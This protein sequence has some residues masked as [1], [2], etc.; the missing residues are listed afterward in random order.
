M[1][2]RLN[3]KF[4]AVKLALAAFALGGFA[5]DAGQGAAD[6]LLH[7]WS[8][9]GDLTDGLGGSA[10]QAFGCD[11]VASR[12][13]GALEL[14]GGRRNTSYADLGAAVPVDGS[15]FTVE[16]WA[17]TDGPREWSRVFEVGDGVRDFLVMTWSHG[18]NVTSE[19]CGVMADGKA[20]WQEGRFAPFVPRLSYHIALAVFRGERG[21]WKMRGWKQRIGGTEAPK[22][23]S[24]D[25]PEGWSPA[26]L[27]SGNLTLGHSL[28]RA[29]QDANAIYDEVRVWR[30]ALAETELAAHAEAGPDALLG[31]CAARRTPTRQKVTCGV[32]PLAPADGARECFVSPNGDDAADGSRA[33]P[34]R[35]IQRAASVASA[36]D[37]VTIRGGVYREWV[38]PA[39]AGAPGR[40]I[41][42][43]AAKGEH[44][45]VT[46]A[47]PVTDWT[48]LA[49]GR[50]MAQVEYTAF[51]GMNPF[52][53]FI[54]GNW[55]PRREDQFFRA[56]LLQGGKPL[57]LFTA[58]RAFAEIRKVAEVETG[59]RM[60]GASFAFAGTPETRIP[61]S[62]I[63]V[64]GMVCGTIVAAFE[65]DPNEM[66]PELTVRPACFYPVREGRD[67]LTLRGIEFRHAAPNWAPPTSEQVA[68]V[69]TNW[70]RGW[71]IEDCE[72]HGVV[73]AGLTL[74]KYGDEFDNVAETAK[75]YNSTVARACAHGLEKVGHHAVRRCRIHHC[76]QFGI[77]G[78]LG[79]M[80]STIEDC[81]ISHC[82]WKQP[83]GGVNM[84]GIDMHGT[85]DTTI[86][87]CRIHHCR[88]PYG[89]IWL[90][91]MSQ[92][93]RVTGN[94]LWGNECQDIYLEVNHGPI[95]VDGNDCLSTRSMR[96][97]SKNVALVDN[98]FRGEFQWAKQWRR[99]PLFEPH[100]VKVRSLDT[101]RC[102][103]GNFIFINN[104]FVKLPRFKGVEHPCR[105][106]DNWIVPATRWQ[107]DEMT[108]DC[109]IEPDP[110]NPR[111]AVR[112]VTSARLGRTVV[113]SQ[114]FPGFENGGEL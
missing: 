36:G 70:S 13:G 26:K 30:R 58:E 15:D 35:T 104:T 98:R 40:P 44:V 25:L 10:A 42:Y 74:G 113:H 52:T 24:C 67:F 101:E 81:E 16:L 29:G 34:W 90:D 62:A 4:A 47:D 87:R 79:G 50:W 17:Q 27:G 6:G 66:T 111:P 56:Q 102:T 105:L 83:F 22:S 41:V 82:Y 93:S 59:A 100:S 94:R 53:D 108:G 55:G 46:G 49:D 86:A 7:R 43:Q 60:D 109:R 23:F 95:T 33:H 112:P 64:P 106:E 68:V 51:G 114:E 19:L 12:S 63:M 89:A 32:E 80:F 54:F 31:G 11:F 96:I 39:H 77:G 21:R 92:G 3:W 48:R 103:C 107:V 57:T 85:V 65:H 9:N 28:L 76:G 5:A 37:V 1:A 99:T 97:W 88:G 71:V 61:G 110:D 20:H 38:K 69:G 8:F 18:R 14:P 91:W 84:G 75:G 45:V 78:S 2:C 73:C 72:I